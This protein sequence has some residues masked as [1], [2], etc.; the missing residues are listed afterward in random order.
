MWTVDVSNVQEH[1]CS[2]VM[3]LTKLVMHILTAAN[4]S[5]MACDTQ[6]NQQV[7]TYAELLRIYASQNDKSPT[8]MDLLRDSRQLGA[9]P[10]KREGI[11]LDFLRIKIARDCYMSQSS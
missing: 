8:G 3:V 9:Q 1:Q 2:G 10:G 4:F 7:V 11:L 5:D 6:V